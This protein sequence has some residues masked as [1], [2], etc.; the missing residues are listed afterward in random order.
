VSSTLHR[1]IAQA[2]RAGQDVDEIEQR[3]IQPAPVAEDEKS[4]LWLYAQA[5]S[6]RP[7]RER[8]REPAPT[9]LGG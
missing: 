4:A 9:R 8:T 5:L 7:H 2:I 6:E 3:I 1:Q